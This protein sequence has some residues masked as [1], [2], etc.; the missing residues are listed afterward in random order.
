MCSLIRPGSRTSAIQD[1]RLCGFG[2][3]IAQLSALSRGSA[4]D[5]SG[6]CHACTAVNG[7]VSH[8]ASA[9]T[10]PPA[11]ITSMNP[12]RLIEWSIDILRVVQQMKECY[13]RGFARACH[14]APLHEH[15]SPWLRSRIWCPH[16]RC[17]ARSKRSHCSVSM[18]MRCERSWVSCRPRPTRSCTPPSTPRCGRWRSVSTDCRACRPRWRWRSPSVPS[19]RSTTWPAA[20]RQ[21]LPH[22][23]RCRFT[24]RWWR[25]TCGCSAKKLVTDCAC[26]KCVVSAACRPKRSSSRWHRSSAGCD[27]S[28]ETPCVSSQSGCRCNDPNTI[29]S[30]R[31]FTVCL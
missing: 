5:A 18:R 23:N 25:S 24:C 7:M 2:A 20:P 12:R 17:T 4:S 13:G 30:E 21:W 14:C 22:A 10:A 11:P 15:P 29:R 8:P 3:S 27:T 9:T 26:S 28:L 1:C 16:W 19:A 31:A 6:P